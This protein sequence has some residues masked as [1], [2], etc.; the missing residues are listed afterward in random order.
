MGKNG[1]L[2]VHPSINLTPA[3]QK[4]AKTIPQFSHEFNNELVRGQDKQTIYKLWYMIEDIFR[5]DILV[6]KKKQLKN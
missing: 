1:S 2:Q 4:G 3:L 6:K 5:Q